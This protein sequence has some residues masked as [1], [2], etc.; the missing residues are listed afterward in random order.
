ML[1]P[2]QKKALSDI[3]LDYWGEEDAT[4]VIDAVLRIADPIEAAKCL[5]AWAKSTEELVA[6]GTIYLAEAKRLRAT[7]QLLRKQK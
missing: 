1:S 4:G 5:E 3:L 7:A 6:D 2:E